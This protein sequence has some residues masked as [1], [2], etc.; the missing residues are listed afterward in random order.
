MTITSIFTQ[1]FYRPQWTPD[2]GLPDLTGKVAI[3]TGGSN[4]LGRE[5]VC[6]LAKKG[7]HVFILSRTCQA[8]KEMIAETGNSK[9]EFIACDFSD[10]S[11]VCAA[12]ETFL[13]K[14]LPLHILVN[15]AGC[16][17]DFSIA[18]HGIET[19]FTINH[20]GPV[21]LTSKLL[22]VLEAS[23]PSRIVNI[24]SMSHIFVY[25]KIFYENINSKKQFDAEVRYNETKLA[26]IHF[27]LELHR[28]LQA[29]YAAQGKEC[30]V[31]VNCVHPGAVSTQMTSDNPS[32][33]DMKNTVL[34]SIRIPV[35]KGA[36]TQIY[37]AGAQ[38][39]EEE[40]LSGKYFVPYCDVAE[41]SSVASSEEG[42]K[43]TW[44]W[45]CY[46]LRTHFDPEFDF[47]I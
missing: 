41:P 26:N 32:G 19:Q 21:L 42:G 17:K 22:P 15:N 10:F 23:Q 46:M 5:T 36:L 11:S 7:A 28:R 40:R 3:V 47:Q 1:M 44:D 34:N 20:F 13:A 37:V 4:G 31:F 35:D 33:Q 30:N 25:P 16:I 2:T 29:K 39:I 45:T 18:Q 24:S 43:T 9:L 12:A 14:G 38:T 6:Q 8:L 27:T